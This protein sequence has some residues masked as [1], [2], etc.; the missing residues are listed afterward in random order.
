MANSTIGTLDIKVLANIASMVSDL[1]KAQAESTRAAREMQAQWNEAG[2]LIKESLRGAFELVGISASIAGFRE[3]MATSMETAAHMQ[4][5]AQSLGASTQTI[6]TLSYAA[7][8]S[9]ANLDSMTGALEKLEESA[10]A[11][12]SGNRQ[13]VEAFRAIGI[14]ASQAAELMRDPDKLIQTVTAHMA[15]FAD[16]SGKT[17]VAMQLMGRGAAENIPLINKLGTEYSELAKRAKDV[18]V[19]MEDSQTRALAAASEKYNEIGQDVKGLANQFTLA[20]LPAIDKAAEKLSDVATSPEIRNGFKAIGDGVDYVVT[21]FGKFNQIASSL[22]AGGLVSHLTDAASAAASMVTRSDALVGAILRVRDV[23]PS[24]NFDW[25][26]AA[27]RGVERFGASTFAAI[28]QG[29]NNVRKAAADAEAYLIKLTNPMVDL[30]AMLNANTQAW[31][32]QAAAIE[33]GSLRARQSIDATNDAAQAQDDFGLHVASSGRAAENASKKQ[34]ELNTNLEAGARAEREAAR[35]V[36]ELDAAHD[37]ALGTIDKLRGDLGGPAA[38]ALSDYKVGMRDLQNQMEKWAIAGGNVDAII[39]TWQEGEELLGEKLALTNEQIA[40]QNDLLKQSSDQL[41]I[42]AQVLQQIPS[43][44]DAA[45]AGLEAY[46]KL[47]VEH[48]DFTGR[49]IQNDDELR[50]ALDRQLPSFVKNKQA[51]HDLDE[52]Y[53]NSQ[54]VLED[55]RNIYQQGLSSIASAVGNFFT[56]QIRSWSDFGKELVGGVKQMIAQI[57]EE[58]LKLQFVN[59]IL[60]A[61]FGGSLGMLPVAAGMFGS[62]TASAATVGGGIAAGGAAAGGTDLFGTATGGISLFNA[63]KTIWSGFSNAASSFWNGGG[64]TMPFANYLGSSVYG[65]GMDTA[66]APSAFG[67]GASIAGGVYAGYNRYQNRYNTSTGLIGG[68][69]YGVGTTALGLGMAG[70][71]TGAGFSAGVGALGAFGPIGWAALI[72]MGIDMLSGGKL[73][74]TSGKV[75][76]GNQTVTTGAGGIDV[77]SVITT[78][79]QKPLFGGAYW[80]EHNVAT[81]PEVLAAWDSFFDGVTTGLK[82]YAAQYG[83]KVPDIIA[84]SFEQT[85]DKHGNITGSTTTIA[86]HTYSGE[87]AD[88]YQQR[89]I[90]ESQLEVLD[91]F[92]AKLDATIDRYRANVDVLTGIVAGLSTAQTMLQSGEKFL[93]LG[94]DQSLSAL[95]NLAAGA[96]QFG[97]TVD[98]ALA[99]IEQAQA[100]YDQFVG[101]FKK[102]VNY[103]D[104]FEATLAGIND[105]MQA[106]IKTANDLAKA[107]GAEGASEQ[108]LANIHASAAKQMADAI[109]ALEQ[110]A[111]SLA[112][113]MGLTDLG[114]LDQVNAEIQRLQAKANGGANAVR[115]FGNAMQTAAQRA[116]DAM[117]LLLGDLSPLND[118]QKLEKAR[119]GLMAGTVTVDQFLQIARRLY[120]SSQKYVDE[121]SFAQRFAGAG[122][123]SQYMSGTSGGAGAGLTE[124][125]RKRL[126]DLLQE[127]QQL[128]AQQ[129]YTNAQTLAQQIAEIAMAKGE[130]WRQVVADM[131][132]NLSELEK[133]LNMSDTDFA[134]FIADIQSKT[135]DNKENTKSIVDAINDMSDAI[136]TTLGGTPHGHSQ[137]GESGAGGTNPAPPGRI[138]HSG[139]GNPRGG[140]SGMST[141]DMREF[142]KAVG[143]EIGNSI[144]R[145]LPR[146]LRS[147]PSRQ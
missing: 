126:Q 125:E 1:G 79:G 144:V 21:N 85:F 2:K 108:D 122:V 60:N 116:T 52:A 7:G 141:D 23:L 113:S 22:A 26:E 50:A 57:I 54:Q 70:V 19:A 4:D 36:R 78:K 53:K 120:A 63:G 77:S 127:Q 111:Q 44:Q 80:K 34:I 15:Q 30:D 75:V 101:Q 114:T 139:H 47:L 32:K 68:A 51:V 56:G 109:R 138:G 133:R 143:R 73:F 147:A 38:K 112:F 39:Q 76:G 18:G 119:Q 115:D 87:T 105:Q 110:S 136:V 96:A 95:L 69:A 17:A 98:Q 46:N 86:G 146:N 49:A 88:Q 130:D 62:G 29:L 91:Q 8:V 48:K 124:A 89:V 11:A 61:I 117:N 72:A 41:L 131:H 134:K 12:A 140:Q 106:N 16:G 65:P 132:L 35:A 20:L 129:D 128:Q 83:A 66:F 6:Q 45:R 145:V 40:A 100:Q 90:D 92:D 3:L 118:Q 94:S 13:S 103:V 27:K 71:A 81:D 31:A 74:G 104:D 64:Q 33:I 24:I 84:S 121:F 37:A 123:G 82:N 43:H 28:E 59:P 99:R 102:P 107:A 142:G 58:F 137:H 135:D 67:W 10:V 55:W 9:G 42:E 93:A 5:M 97:E 14:S 25:F